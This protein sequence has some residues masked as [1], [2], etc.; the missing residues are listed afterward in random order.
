MQQYVINCDIDSSKICDI[1]NI[2]LVDYC[3]VNVCG[4]NKSDDEYWGKKIKKNVCELQ[5]QI[6][7]KNLGENISTVVITPIIGAQKNINELCKTVKEI[8]RLCVMFD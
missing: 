5:F 8:I 2:I 6:S 7:V 4:Y 1:M 3:K